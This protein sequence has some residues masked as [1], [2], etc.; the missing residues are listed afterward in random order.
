LSCHPSIGRAAFFGGRQEIRESR[1]YSHMVAADISAAYPHSMASHPFA[2]ALREAGKRTVLDPTVPGLAKAT[3][4]VPTDLAFYPLPRR[5]ATDIIQFS[6]G[7]FTGVW[8]WCELAAA[9]ELDCTVQVEKVWAPRRTVDLFSSWWGLARDG[10]RLP[11]PAARL[12]K[13]M[14]NSLWG[15][16]AMDGTDRARVRWSD[17]SGATSYTVKLDARRLPHAWTTHIAAETASRVRTRLLTEGL[18]N[19]RFAP[20]H[21]DT[22]GMIIRRSAELPTPAGEEP[23]CWR[24]K[25][26]MRKVEIRA[27]QVYRYQ[28]GAGCGVTHAPWHYVTAGVPQSLAPE[29]FKK[30]SGT[31]IG[32]RGLD[33]VLPPGNAHDLKRTAHFVQEARAVTTSA[34]GVRLG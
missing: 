4:T 25:T 29:V 5:I 18:Y 12:A 24:K 9:Q 7:T 21:I 27:P 34:Y 13:M 11:G 33:L 20:V 23:G 32:Y 3:V 16:F 8:P 30:S 10:R 1:T 15:L 14:T 28:C 17:E 31:R 22:D 26:A 19:R 6:S 2:L